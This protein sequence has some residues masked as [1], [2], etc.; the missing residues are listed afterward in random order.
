LAQLEKYRKLDQKGTVIAEYVWIDANNG[1]R[2]KCKVSSHTPEAFFFFIHT[3]LE[4][5][6]THSVVS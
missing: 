6:Y 5:V 2:S 1:I 3:R 4:H